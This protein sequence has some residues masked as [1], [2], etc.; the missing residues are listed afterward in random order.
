MASVPVID[1]RKVTRDAVTLDV[2]VRVVNMW[3]VKARLWLAIQ[4]CRLAAV[5]GGI[6]LAV[7]Q[8]VGVIVTE[9]PPA[10]FDE[11]ERP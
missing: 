4:I 9:Q 5:V 1:A 8:Q 2:E 7:N 10:Q 3:Q 6:G 11:I